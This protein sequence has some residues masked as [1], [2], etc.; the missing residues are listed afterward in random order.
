MY[1]SEALLELLESFEQVPRDVPFWAQGPPLDWGRAGGGGMGGGETKGAHFC[2]INLL[3][4]TYATTMT[5][6][7]LWRQMG[8]GEVSYMGS[9]M[10]KVRRQQYAVMTG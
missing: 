6:N 4:N 8:G 1:D 10:R 7:V 2:M 3:M 9:T 5:D